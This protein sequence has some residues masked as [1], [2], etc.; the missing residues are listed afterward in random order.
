MQGR[1]KTLEGLVISERDSGETGKSVTLLT[2][3]LGCID[4]YVRGG[5]KSNKSV[6]S[7]QL[8]CYAVFSLEEKRGADNT[9]RY[10]YNSSE[11]IQ[12][13]YNIRLDAKR[14]AL[15]CY[16][17]E[18][19]LF[20]A[21]SSENADEI[22]RLTLNTLHFLNK[23]D[24]SE[25]LLKSIF[26]LRLLCETGFRPNLIGCCH[27]YRPEDDE[28]HF[29]LRSGNLECHDCVTSDDAMYDYIFD[30]TMLHIVRFIALVEY[31]RLFNF[32]I[33]E[34]YQKQLSAFTEDFA[35]YHYGK[36]FQKLRFYKML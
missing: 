36:K 19:L 15:A 22:M 13:F 11:P 20:A 24:R 33:S 5:R 2:R 6:S 14:M 4:V 29:N 32:K 34:K 7:T 3:E 28:M 9:T 10:Y 27:C 30:K 26:E 35:Q 25:L 12:L 31:E 8:F 21:E 17:A 23:G 1:L 16:F 18:L